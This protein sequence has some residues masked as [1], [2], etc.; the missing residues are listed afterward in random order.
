MPLHVLDHP[1][2]AHLVTILRN[3][4]TEPEQFRAA[5]R[6]LSLMLALEATKDLRTTKTQVQT[7]VAAA[8]G[9][10]LAET[11]AV[12]PILRAGLGMLDPILEIFPK[13]D[14]GYIGLER[15]EETAIAHSYYCKLPDLTNKVAVCLDPMLATGGSA[16]QAVFLIKA[17]SPRAVVMVSIV[18]A[19]EG[20][21]KMADDHPEVEIFTAALDQGLNDRRYIVPGVGDFGD[22]LFGT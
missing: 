9:Y 7:P 12:V 14:V 21:Q 3:E 4:T 15:H 20:A 13:V 1:L 17:R 11:V 5:T 22:R 8:D 16:S 10:E 2:A 19:P 18:A 6:T